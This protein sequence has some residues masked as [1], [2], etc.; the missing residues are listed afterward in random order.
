MNSRTMPEATI[1]HPYLT[2]AKVARHFG[3]R[4]WQ[5]RRL[6]ELELLP[7]PP[8]A[9]RYRLIAQSDLPA[10]EAALRKAGY[11]PGKDGVTL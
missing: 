4:S 1:D 5:V 9:G 2:T 7:D 11:L 6:F 8:R 10:V 3:V